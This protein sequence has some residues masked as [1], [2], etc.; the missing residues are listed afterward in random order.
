MQGRNERKCGQKDIYMCEH[1][2]VLFIQTYICSYTIWP[3]KTIQKYLQVL[4][5]LTKAPKTVV[6]R[7]CVI[8]HG[9]PG[10]IHSLVNLWASSNLIPG[11]LLLAGQQKGPHEL[12]P[13]IRRIL[14]RI[15]ASK[16]L[17]K[18]YQFISTRS[19][20]FLLNKI[21]Q[22]V[23]VIRVFLDWNAHTY[24]N[25]P[26]TLTWSV[27]GLDSASSFSPGSPLN[28]CLNTGFHRGQDRTWFIKPAGN[29][30]T[31]RIPSCGR[32]T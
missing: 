7:W 3:L 2:I 19:W 10:G 16:L 6:K 25:I 9:R 28:T 8:H 12:R 4:T 14:G 32:Q 17:Q 27:S 18:F 24:T 29:S 26:S 15:P 22:D 23:Q 1:W 11:W 13:A 21:A 30:F 5:V 20:L 31:P